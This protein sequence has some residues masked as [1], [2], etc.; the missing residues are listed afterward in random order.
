MS[1]EITSY[2][3]KS[4]AKNLK[5]ALSDFELE[6]KHSQSLEIIAQTFGYKDWNTLSAKLNETSHSNAGEHSIVGSQ[7]EAVNPKKWLESDRHLRERRHYFEAAIADMTFIR[8]AAGQVSLSEEYTAEITKDF[9]ICDHPVTCGEF[10]PYLMDNRKQLRNRELDDYPVVDISWINAQDYISWLNSFAEDEIYRLPTE[11][12]WEYAC[13]AGSTTR[14]SFGDSVEDF[15]KYG[16]YFGN[17][18]G[19]LKPV[20]Q[21]LPN[22]WGL[23]DMHGNISEWVQDFYHE[24]PSGVLK[25]PIGPNSGRDRV[26]R[27][28]SFTLGDPHHRSVA[29]NEYHSLGSADRNSSSPLSCREFIGFRLIRQAN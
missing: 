12:E 5:S 23:F 22:P 9:S 1:I 24:Y 13:R 26:I 10:N 17:S 7:K 29:L 11:A 4:I 8:I 21:L 14:F 19:M 28:G 6:L 20:R 16:W 25:D 27:G 18:Q 2:N 15:H 3:I